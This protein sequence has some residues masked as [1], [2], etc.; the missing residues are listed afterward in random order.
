MKLLRFGVVV[1]S[2][3]AIGCSSS[4]S[5]QAERG[6]ADKRTGWS[7]F[8]PMEKSPGEYGLRAVAPY[9]RRADRAAIER[10]IS[11]A[12]QGGKSGSSHLDPRTGAGYYVNCNPDNRQLLNGYVP[13]DPRR[14]PHS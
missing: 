6:I 8:T 10:A 4:S 11:S 5:A 7:R 1:V 13:A 9:F 3:A 12:C 14:R 2:L